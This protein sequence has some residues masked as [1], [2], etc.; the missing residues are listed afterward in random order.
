MC[1]F[2]PPTPPS[3]P[4]GVTVRDEA[5]AAP[6]PVAQQRD[7]FLYPTHPIH[8]HPTHTPPAWLSVTRRAPRPSWSQS[9]VMCFFTPPTPPSHATCVTVRD[10]AS[11]A[12][13]LVAKQRDVF[14]YP[15]HTPLTPHLHDCPW[16]GERR[17]PA[18]RTAAWCVSLL[19]PHPT[20]TPPTPPTPHLRDCP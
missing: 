1:F 4:T 16:R 5:S 7:V 19:H 11:A 17:A 14:L 6:Q 9:S 3:H 20:N 15:T 2:T 10:E 13:Q 18:G 8:S 12:P